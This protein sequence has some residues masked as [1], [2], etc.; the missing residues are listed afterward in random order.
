MAYLCTL[1]ASNIK[2]MHK[3]KIKEPLLFDYDV[4]SK[5]DNIRDICASLNCEYGTPGWP[6]SFGEA[7][8]Q[9]LQ[10]NNIPSIR[11]LSLF[12]GAGG[13]D[14]GFHDL[15]FDIIESVEIEPK[16]CNTLIINS[17]EGKKFSNSKPNCIDIR[18]YSG[19]NLGNID[20][21]IGG[22]PCQ[23]FSAAGR[24]QGGV[25]GTTDA[26]G[27]LF[28]EYVRLLKK[29][30]PIGFLFE[31]VYGI[32]GAQ[33]GEPWKEIIKSFSEV[34]YK[35]HY[36]ILD[37][38]DYGVPQHRERLIIVG[39]RDGDFKFPRPINGFDSINQEPFYN[40]GCAVKGLKLS[41]E[42]KITGI[43]GRFG[44]L[45][46]DI[47]PGLNY[48]FYTKELGHPNP[49]FAWR[50]KFSDFMYKADPDM[51]VRTIK[52]QGGQYTGPLHWDTRYFSCSEFK[53]LQTFPDD[54]EING[55]KQVAVH[56]IGNSVPPQLARM[57]ALAIRIQ[58][59]GTQ[60]PFNMEFIPDNVVLSFRKKKRDLTEYYREK[61]KDAIDKLYISKT[62][63]EFKNSSFYL[64][65]TSKFKY[66]K[67]EKEGEF[68]VNVV[69]EGKDLTIKIERN[70][71]K[72]K[73]ST[74]QIEPNSVWSLPLERIYLKVY[75]DD[76]FA[77]TAAWKVLD[78][79][80]IKH[81]WKAD[82]VQ[83]NGYY[84]YGSQI[85]CS[86][87]SQTLNLQN[88]MRPIIEGEIVGKLISTNEFAS[89][90]GT[91]DDEIMKYAKILRDL[92]YEIRN[93]HTNPQ[94]PEGIWLIPY[95]FPT[96]LPESVQ[97][98]KKLE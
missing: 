50:S 46:N 12:S 6:D 54:Y 80:L 91:T 72:S 94:I 18:E 74:I 32:I 25:L 52:A 83:L 40:A 63:E 29:L 43:S 51:P 7:L 75:C 66:I 56:Q 16:F 31:N 44:A 48:S 13:L 41:K 9:Y 4:I 67:S 53:R 47:P 95:K 98:N 58:V 57:L 17:G 42:E 92:G 24:R 86:L 68:K 64:T 85:V 96:L 88:L 65:L 78:R 27:V 69:W 81:N 55:V 84:Q 77:V 20:F 11:T 87:N 23:T 5:Y 49:I 59:F 8:N 22:P 1:D 39:L 73:V 26:R 3:I 79:I 71:N 61:A 97:L 82:L 35:L 15:G 76:W 89:I 19:D 60:F 36:R 30:K 37:A 70:N 10:S 34:G 14:I 38:A 33:N 45:I 62:K 28:R 21:I 2:D 93:T 90:I